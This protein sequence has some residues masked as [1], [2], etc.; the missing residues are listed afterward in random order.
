MR[1]HPIELI[2]ERAYQAIN[3]EDLNSFVSIYAEDAVLVVKPG[4]N[5]LG[6]IQ[7]G[8]AFG[9]IAANFNHTL[10][11]RHVG[12][13]VLEAGDAALVMVRAMVSASNLPETRRD[14]AYV[15]KRTSAGKWLCKI[16]NAYGH[17]LISNDDSRFEIPS[18]A[19]PSLT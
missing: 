8:V 18:D 9:Q 7:I 17:G 15:F 16:D 14:A 5:A 6:R 13:N 11:V 10:R 12:I 19:S 2:L 4:L 1:R 3:Q